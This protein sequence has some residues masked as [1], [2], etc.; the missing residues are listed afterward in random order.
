MKDSQKVFIRGVEDRGDEVQQTLINLGGN[1]VRNYNY[2]V[3]DC[4]YYINHDEEIRCTEEKSEMGLILLDNYTELHL[5]EKWKDGDVLVNSEGLFFVLK[6]DFQVGGKNTAIGAYCSVSEHQV[7][8]SGH[9]KQIDYPRLASPSEVEHFH[10]LMHKHGK[11]WDAEKKQVVDWKWEPDD[12]DIYYFLDD[13]GGVDYDEWN[14]V[15]VDANR[16]NFGNCFRTE[17]EAEAMA[18]KVKKLL[19][20]E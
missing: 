15:E 20:G 1:V 19:K 16:Y 7:C 13:I 10:E 12:G 4:L 18:E 11:D 8:L 14:D 17:E 6:G 9:L 3:S 2:N 5:P